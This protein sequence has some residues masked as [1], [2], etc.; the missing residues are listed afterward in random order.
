M[1]D[2]D[3]IDG[4][5]PFLHLHISTFG[6]T[7]F[8]SPIRAISRATKP[9]GLRSARGNPVID[10]EIAKV[11]AVSRFVFV[12]EAQRAKPTSQRQT[13]ENALKHPNGD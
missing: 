11:E 7:E 1:P 13:L 10:F 5:S 4:S 12:S 2:K 6:Q 8:P 9:G 3:L